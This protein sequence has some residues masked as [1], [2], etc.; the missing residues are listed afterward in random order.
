MLLAATSQT[1][2]NKYSLSC[3]IENGARPLGAAGLDME[4]ELLGLEDSTDAALLRGRDGR[5][6]HCE[7]LW[8]VIAVLKV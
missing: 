2:M 3:P 6:R 8:C 7:R 1:A 5:G 4:F